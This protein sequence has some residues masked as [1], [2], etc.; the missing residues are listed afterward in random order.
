MNSK[1]NTLILDDEIE[2]INHL[3]QQL[4]FYNT[5]N[6][7]DQFTDFLQ[8]KKFLKHNSNIDLIFLDIMLHPENG[9]EIAKYLNKKYPNIKVIFST[10]EPSYALDAFDVSPV[11]Y[12]TKPINSLKL[13]SAINK[14]QKN[15][16][17]S[18]NVADVKIGIKIK[19][20]IKMI[21]I[22]QIILIKKEFRH[23]KIYLSNNEEILSNDSLKNLYLN[24]NKFGFILIN[25]TNIIPISGIDS[26]EFNVIKK[27]YQIYLKSG[28]TIENISSYK[29][30]DIKSELAK[31]NWIL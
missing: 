23:S 6:L 19:N 21:N 2:A 29:L 17:V 22:S 10:A 13:D 27:N 8:L 1:I 15:K 12:I 11:D 28:I 26:I 30:K 20:S 18:N 5:I 16:V 31:F 4:S 25:R 9:I 14:V 24:L 3:K 7:V